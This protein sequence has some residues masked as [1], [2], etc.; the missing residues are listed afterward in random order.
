MERRRPVDHGNT[1]QQKRR[2]RF[3]AVSFVFFAMSAAWAQDL[4]QRIGAI[5]AALHNREFEAALELL[6]PA[7]QMEP[8][9]ELL[10]T[11]QGKAYTG[12]GRD[13][14]ALASFGNALRIAPDYIPGES[15]DR[16]RRR[17]RGSDSG[18]AASAATA[19]R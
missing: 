6:R 15:A 16:F 8:R 18:P 10:W 1:L 9:N 2:A 5:N 4:A 7:L 17:Q 19:K 12:E 3:A 14:E 13:K 11:M